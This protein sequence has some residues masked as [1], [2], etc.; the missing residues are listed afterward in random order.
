MMSLHMNNKT[1][2]DRE[3]SEHK[4]EVGERL[5]AKEFSASIEM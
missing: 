1:Q 2:E 3:Q 5:D 4:L